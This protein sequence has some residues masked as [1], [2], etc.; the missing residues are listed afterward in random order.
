MAAITPG[1]GSIEYFD[2]F[3]DYSSAQVLRYFTG[4]RQNGPTIVSGGGRNGTNCLQLYPANNNDVYFAFIATRQIMTAG[5]AFKVNT[6]S[7]TPG[8]VCYL[9]DS[10]TPQCDL[11]LAGDGTWS[12]TRNNTVLGSSNPGLVQPGV[13]CYVEWYLKIDPT[14]GATQVRI[15]GTTVINLSN[16]N[17]RQTAN[18]YATNF[19]FSDGFS[20]TTGGNLGLFYV[21]DFYL[22]NQ[23]TFYGDSRIESRFANGNGATNAWTPSAGSNYQN[24]NQANSDDDTTYNSSANVGDIDLYTFPALSTNAGLVHA[25]M[26]V[27]VQRIDTAGSASSCPTYRSASGTNYFGATQTIGAT[28]YG[29]YMDIQTTDPSTSGNWT[30]AG[31]NGF[32]YGAKRIS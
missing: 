28:T 30:I 26:T 20:G 6:L 25:V 11:R 5:F 27:G 13:W 4:S 22:D 15:N 8:T 12:V 31:V 19:G 23:G 3:D 21:D 18:S 24:I 14:V 1:S 17:T 10:A 29:A 16:Q 9:A 32:Q 7:G 2:G